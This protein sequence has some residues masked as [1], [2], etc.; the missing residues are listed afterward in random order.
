MAKLKN[1]RKKVKK[2]LYEVPIRRIYGS[3]VFFKVST[4]NFVACEFE[5]FEH[6]YQDPESRLTKKLDPDPDLMI[7]NT[8]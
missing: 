3:C 5:I 4:S 1:D 8:A 7:R 6:Q 2:V